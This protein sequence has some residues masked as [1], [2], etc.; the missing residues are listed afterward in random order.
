MTQFI[1]CVILVSMAK[2]LPQILQKRPFSTQAALSHGLSK[3]SLTRMVAS[4]LLERPSRG[5]Y[6]ASSAEENAG[7]DPYQVATLRCGLPSA[8]CLLSALEHYHLTDQIPK[9]TWM[10]VPD[11]KRV[12]SK[13]LKLIRSRNP[14]W[15]IGIK[16]NKKYWITTL[17]RT[18]VD[19]LVY[20]RMIGSQVALSALKAAIQEKKIKLGSLYDMAKKM[21]VIHRIT[22]YLEVLAS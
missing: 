10:L 21:G 5:V 22:P 8:V 14:Q 2:A 1:I 7:E 17:E 4:G 19:C 18:L 15:E 9:H 16:K 13:D 20:R 6:R 11:A 3:A 12:V